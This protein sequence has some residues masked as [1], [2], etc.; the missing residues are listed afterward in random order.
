MVIE[1]YM[2]DWLADFVDRV[3]HDDTVDYVEWYTVKTEDEEDEDYTIYNVH[4]NKKH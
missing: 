3:R 1:D 4:K 2:D